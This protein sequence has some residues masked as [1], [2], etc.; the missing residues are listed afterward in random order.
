[1]NTTQTKTSRIQPREEVRCA[2][3]HGHGTDAFGV[4]PYRSACCAC[5]G[6]GVLS[7]S[8]PDHRC[9]YCEG[10]GRFKA[11]RCPVCEGAG[12]IPDQ[13][14][15][16]RACPSCDGLALQRSSGLACLTCRGRGFVPT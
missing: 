5:G 6:R 7:V 3:C 1:M 11:I 10:T 12:M 13:Q 15:P 2:F 16:T 14:A 8:V 4:L 9:A